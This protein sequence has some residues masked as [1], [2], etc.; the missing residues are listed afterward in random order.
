MSEILESIR[1]QV[2]EENLFIGN[3]FE[4]GE[5]SVDLTGVSEDDRVV[6]DLDKLF[7]S[8]RG[9]K[10]QCECILFCFNATS[11][12]VAVSNRTQRW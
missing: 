9:G 5:C 1:N 8:G 10:K 6:V 11:S 4:E 2:G 3:L 12:F 7:P